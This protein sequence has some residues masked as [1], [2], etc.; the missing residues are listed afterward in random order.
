MS[1]NIFL[2]LYLMMLFLQTIHIF[3]EIGFKAYEIAVSLNKYLWVASFLVFASYLPLVLILLEFKA[4]Y[5]LAFFAAILALGNGI[6]HLI[7]YI[8]TNSYRGT[9]GAGV[10]SGVPLGI[11]G[12]IVLVNLISIVR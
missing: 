7:G 10:F 6:I 8:K 4:G 12:G 2:I 1:N 11:I 5:Y 3:E 9:L